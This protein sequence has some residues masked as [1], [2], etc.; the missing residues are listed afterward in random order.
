M[1][2]LKGGKCALRGWKGKAWESL[3]LTQFSITPSL[4]KYT[5]NS[6]RN[7]SAYRHF[8]ITY[9]RGFSNF[10]E[11]LLSPDPW[12]KK[13]VFYWLKCKYI[14]AV[15]ENDNF[16]CMVECLINIRSIRIGMCNSRINHLRLNAVK[17]LPRICLPPST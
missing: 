1:F 4:V 11:I 6:V 14:N 2:K 3:P 13:K 5:D 17:D 8:C 10:R 16:R 7:I 9:H 12:K 15:Y